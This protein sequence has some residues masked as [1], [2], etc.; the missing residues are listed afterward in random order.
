MISVRRQE[1]CGFLTSL[2]PT[3]IVF[4]RNGILHGVRRKRKLK[5]TGF[6]LSS[7]AQREIFRRQLNPDDVQ[8]VLDQPEQKVIGKLNRVIYQSR[9]LKSNKVYLLRAVIDES[10]DP[11]LVVTVYITSN[12]L[13]YWSQK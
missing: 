11:N 5:L 1:T 13:K 4:I 12:V 8:K 2:F 9:I 10:I 7:H 3:C 6:R